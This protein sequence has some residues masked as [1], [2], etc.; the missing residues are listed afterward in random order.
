MRPGGVG[1]P[2]PRKLSQ[3]R[4]SREAILT[5]QSLQ[6]SI[7]ANSLLNSCNS[8]SR[9]EDISID[10]DLP[11]VSICVNGPAGSFNSRFSE[12]PLLNTYFSFIV[13]IPVGGECRFVKP[14][15]HFLRFS[16]SPEAC[17]QA[18]SSMLFF[19]QTSS[20]S[21]LNWMSGSLSV[22]ICNNSPLHFFISDSSSCLTA[23]AINLLPLS[24]LLK[25]LY[26]WVETDFQST[27]SSYSKHFVIASAGT[28]RPTHCE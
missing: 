19:I 15:Q 22:S 16:R 21:S 12:L 7:R 26:T 27:S 17:F 3:M 11:Q 14:L 20:A 23:P 1:E 4:V 18:C 9:D 28:T 2:L 10:S 24:L 13:I 5:T 8:R 25:M 6:M